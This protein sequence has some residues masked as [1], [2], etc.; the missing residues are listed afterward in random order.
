M[1]VDNQTLERL[2]NLTLEEYA[3]NLAAFEGDDAE[4]YVKLM[5]SPVE[6]KVTAQKGTCEDNLYEICLKAQGKYKRFLDLRRKITTELVEE[7]KGFNL[8]SVLFDG[9]YVGEPE[10]LLNHRNDSQ[11]EILYPV[12]GFG[13]KIAEV[14]FV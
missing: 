13:E 1:E 5:E 9:I 6:V 10:D 7:I 14:I 8:M 3:G 11:A 12:E 4:T 2:S